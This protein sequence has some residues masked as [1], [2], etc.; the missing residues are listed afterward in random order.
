MKK[1]L[2]TAKEFSQLAGLT[3]DRVYELARQE[4]LPATRFG[5]QV[6]IRRADLDE[7]LGKDWERKLERDQK[8]TEAAP[9]GGR[10]V[11]RNA[12]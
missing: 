9:A 6:Y 1:A 12:V 5:R 4:K 10:P 7:Y 2:L 11:R 8:E 3:R